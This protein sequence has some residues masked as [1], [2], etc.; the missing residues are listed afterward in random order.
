MVA[1]ISVVAVSKVLS[2]VGLAQVED[3]L[4]T[5]SLHDVWDAGFFYFVGI[6]LAVGAAVQRRARLEVQ[7]SCFFCGLAVEFGGWDVRWVADDEV[8]FGVV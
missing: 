6:A 3:N 7:A 2:H 8:N 5:G 1:A 4:S